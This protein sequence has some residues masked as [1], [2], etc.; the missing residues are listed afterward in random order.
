[1]TGPVRVVFNK[2]D[3]TVSAVA[4]ALLDFTSPTR[5]VA[6]PPDAGG[7]KR[8][9]AVTAMHPVLPFGVGRFVALMVQ[10]MVSTVG[11]GLLA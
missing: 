2:P 11:S 7:T 10:E 4:V 5:F 3:F 1:M 8:T 9:L 6:S